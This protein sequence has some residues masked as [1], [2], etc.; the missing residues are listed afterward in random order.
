MLLPQGPGLNPETQAGQ[1]FPQA[2]WLVVAENALREGASQDPIE[3]SPKH[4]TAM[5]HADYLWGPR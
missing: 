1:P 5:R 3:N 4:R 2:P